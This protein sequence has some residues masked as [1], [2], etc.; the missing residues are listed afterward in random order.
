MKTHY[1]TLGIRKTAS[2]LE[3]KASYHKLAKL[4]HPDVTHLAR[5]EAEK[6]IREINIAYSVLSKP[7]S[8]S[9]YDAKLNKDDFKIAAEPER[10][11]SCDKPTTYWRTNIKARVCVECRNSGL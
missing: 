2:S 10:C 6:Q 4:Y 8:R 3:I 7:R 5:V 9:S 11:S 1:E